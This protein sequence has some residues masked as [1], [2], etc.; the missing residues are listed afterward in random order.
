MDKT[1]LKCKFCNE[2]FDTE[3]R[4]PKMLYACGHSICASCLRSFIGRRDFFHCIEDNTKITLTDTKFESFPPNI[5]L[6]NMLKDARKPSQVLPSD[7]P[8]KN[9]AELFSASARRKSNQL[10]KEFSER[11]LHTNDN[12]SLVSENRTVNHKSKK[13]NRRT[14][15]KVIDETD[16]SLFAHNVN[17]EDSFGF[18]NPEDGEYCETH[19]K[20]LEAVCEERACQMRVCFECGLFGSH[21]VS[22]I[23]TF[24]PKGGGIS[25]KGGKPLDWIVQ[26][27][28]GGH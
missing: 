26:N 27:F 4:S 25:A 9:Q 6:L 14:H 16:K 5:V 8:P 11:K 1:Y 10:R 24:S 23:G 20:R 22:S 2:Q 19:G 28:G 17:S 21:M 3:T 12:F 18:E 15:N 13:D 7:L